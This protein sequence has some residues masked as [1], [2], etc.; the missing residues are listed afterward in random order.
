MNQ[1]SLKG[2]SA[3][4]VMTNNE[5]FTGLIYTIDAS[6][7]LIVLQLKDKKQYSFSILKISR[8]KSVVSHSLPQIQEL[9][10]VT[11]IT[12]STL[13]KINERHLLQ[14]NSFNPNA[15]KEGQAIFN[16]LSKT[17]PCR[18][19]QLDIVLMDEISIKAPYVKAVGMKEGVSSG[20]V[21][22]AAQ[23]LSGVRVK[24]QLE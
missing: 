15:S 2:V 1:Q 9:E 19:D 4:I 6:L 5:T 8:I 11:L 3:T 18:W 14:L 23:V 13:S 24:L 21:S 20:L 7:D 16:E 17:M 12:S 10:P 22:R